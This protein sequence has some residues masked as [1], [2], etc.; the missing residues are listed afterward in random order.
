MGS[1]EAKYA[2]NRRDP[3]LKHYNTVPPENEALRVV[4][5]QAPARPQKKLT[6]DVVK[7]RV[8]VT[9]KRL[10]VLQSKAVMEDRSA[11]YMR[12][13]LTRP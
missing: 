8:T 9:T 2:R 6:D 4:K 13:I 11:A 7:V 12:E 10:S 1:L 3:N 5:A